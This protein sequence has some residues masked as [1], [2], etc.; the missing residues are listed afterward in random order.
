[1]ELP[2]DFDI[3]FYK[4]YYMDL[5]HM[6]DEELI[7][8]YLQYGIYE[9]RIYK[10]NEKKIIDISL[11]LNN[12]IEK[13]N[14]LK[15]LTENELILYCVKYGK[16][17]NYNVPNDFDLEYYKNYYHDLINMTHKEVINHY[18]NYGFYEKRVYKENND[19][20]NKIK[21]RYISLGGWCGTAWSLR[22]NSLNDCDRSLPFDFIRSKF[23]G[24]ID[25]FEN[26]FENFFP[27][28]LEV[29]VID[30]YLYSNLSIRGKY[31]GFFH[32]NLHDNNITEAFHRRI[33]RLDE[34]LRNKDERIIFIR[35]VINRNYEEEINLGSRF[36]EIIESKYPLL[37]YLLIFVIP[38]QPYTRYY[39]N[40]SDKIFIMTINDITHEWDL[41][42]DKYKVI[43]DYIKENDLFNNIPEANED[44]KINEII[45]LEKEDGIYSFRDDN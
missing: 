25:C 5:Q 38:E 35:T 4:N 40:I 27:K 12:E 21:T 18:I 24:I 37:K 30:N 42:K 39:K 43:Y 29:D 36:S 17:N 16:F 1:M 10:N 7:N 11:C 34:Y 45:G 44:I 15:F 23:E 31:F 26:N 22:H 20:I 13:Y 6:N 41:I 8:H 19:D 2:S 14:D 3:E 9:N 28:R 33:R 32:H